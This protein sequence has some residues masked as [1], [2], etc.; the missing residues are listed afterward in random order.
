MSTSNISLPLSLQLPNY[1]RSCHLIFRLQRDN[2]DIKVTLKIELDTNATYINTISYIKYI[3]YGVLQGPILASSLFMIY[4]NNVS[5]ASSLLFS[6]LFAD[7]T[8]VFIEVKVIEVS[9]TY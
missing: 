9:S 5:R 3:T 2:Q 1:I 7:D 6:I 4:V 8:S